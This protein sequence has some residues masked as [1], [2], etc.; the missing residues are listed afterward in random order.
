MLEWSVG[1]FSN[2]F[3]FFKLHLFSIWFY[4]VSKFKYHSYCIFLAPGILLDSKLKY[5]TAHLGTFTW[6]P[7]T[8]YVKTELSVSILNMFLSFH[9]LYKHYYY[10]PS[11]K[12]MESSCPLRFTSSL[13]VNSISI[14]L[15]TY[16]ESDHFHI[17]TVTTFFFFTVITV[18]QT[19]IFSCP[20]P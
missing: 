13:S 18:V 9:P 6:M 20:D 8:K 10:S 2:W 17:S 19:A 15:K 4:L 14:T 12:G 1:Q 7:T 11:S 5:S 16:S 3:L